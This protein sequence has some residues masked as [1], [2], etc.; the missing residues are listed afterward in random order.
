MMEGTNN[1]DENIDVDNNDGVMDDIS[2]IEEEDSQ[3]NMH[4]QQNI[5][6][7]QRE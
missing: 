6:K 1:Q 7:A 3:Q 2:D 4:E 5:A